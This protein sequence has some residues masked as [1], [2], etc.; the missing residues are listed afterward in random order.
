MLSWPSTTRLMEIATVGCAFLAFAARAPLAAPPKRPSPESPTVTQPTE[1]RPSSV[2]TLGGVDVIHVP[3]PTRPISTWSLTLRV[4]SLLDPPGKEGLAYLTGQMLTRGAGQLTQETIADELDFL[5]SHLSVSTGRDTTTLTGDALTRNL[6]AFEALLGTVLAEPTFPLDELDKLKR[7]TLAELAQVQDN[8]S[9]LG[10]R[11]FVKRLFAGHPYG[12]PLKGTSK[13][14]AA[15]SR[16]DVVD[17]YRAHFKRGGAVLGVSGDADRARV[18][19]FLERTAARLPDAPA[20]AMPVPPATPPAAY[21]ALIVDKPERS[22]TQVYIGHP[23]LDANHPDFVPL[24]V[25]HTLFGGTFTAKLSHEIREKR[26]WSY[27]AYSYLSTD[28]HLGTFT[29]RFYPA[30]GDTLPAIQLADELFAALVKDGVTADE[31][32]FAKSY[33][34]NGHAFAIDTADKRLNELLGAHLQGRPADWVERFRALVDAVTPEQVNAAIRRH[35][36][37]DQVV[38]VVVATA[39]DLAEPL[40][41]WARVKSVEQVDYRTE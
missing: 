41:T 23:T 10:Q 35:L 37:P 3:D 1:S 14:I 38:V 5:G 31:V 13:T 33:L 2:D 19:T 8:D 29:I 25:A 24:L 7:Q 21:G 22:Q 6:D 40:R 12:R 16:Q 34:V 28:R 30:I 32:A 18:A 36:T 20:S 15:I 11:F 27:G 26:G 17:F 39:K 9:A 4:G